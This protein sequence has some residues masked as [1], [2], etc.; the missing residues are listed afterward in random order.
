MSEQIEI[1]DELQEKEPSSIKLVLALAIAGLLSGFVL[2]GS[3]IYTL[4][5]IQE[6]KATMLKEAIFKVLE[7]CDTYKTLVVNNDKLVFLSEND[8]DNKSE[9][10]YLGYNKDKQPIGFAI[11]GAEPGFQDII[12]VIYGY[13][14]VSSS[15]I[16]FEVL[17]SKETPGLGDKIFK[18]A[19]FQ[20][21]FVKLQVMPN[22]ISVKNGTKMKENEVEAITG[23]TISS[24]AVVRLLNKSISIWKDKID[25]FINENNIELSNE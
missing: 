18:D 8:E 7:S 17:E 1:S 24:K 3:Y 21:N 15:I 11:P 16:G 4:P 10:I 2:V 25:V 6:N 23:A 20:E 22:I 14:S 12:G 19:A 13:N 5:I 9:K